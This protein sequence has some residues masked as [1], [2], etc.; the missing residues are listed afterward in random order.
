MIGLARRWWWLLTL[1][2]LGLIAVATL[3]PLDH[4]PP[5]PGND[6]THHLIG[7][8]VVALPTAL[9]MPAYWW[10][11]CLGFVAYGGMI[12]LI[13]PSVNRHAEWA[14]F[15]ANGCGVVLGMVLGVLLNRVAP[16]ADAP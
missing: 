3:T 6:K 8:A 16:A 7:F 12:E 2:F 4:L 10:L 5:P 11:L 1:V 14:D 13:Q 9:R 15:V